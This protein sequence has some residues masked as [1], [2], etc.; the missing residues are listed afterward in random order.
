MS[1]KD[2]LTRE[3][4]AARASL[5]SDLQYDV[6]F[7]QTL[8]AE[9]YGCEVTIRFACN[10]PGGSTFVDFVGEGIETAELNGR[11]VA[12]D[13][14]DG[15]RLRLEGLEARNELHVVATGTYERSGVGL[16]RFEDPVDGRVYTHSDFEPF[17]AHRA[18]PCFDQPDLKGAFRFSVRTPSD[19]LAVSNGRQAGEPAPDGDGFVRWTFEETPPISPY[20]TAL[21]TGPFHVVREKG[22]LDLGLW[23]RQSLAEY[24]DRDAAELFEITRQGFAFFQ[25]RFDYPYPFGVKYDQVFVPDFIP[26][27]MENPGCITYNELYLFRS[28]VTDASRERRAE[29][30][31]HEMAHMWFGDLVT[32]RW[33]DDVWLNESFATYVSV[34]A[35]VEGTR[36]ADAWVTFADGEKTWAYQQ[37]QLPT[38]HAITTDV[39]DTQSI[40]LNFDGITYAKGASV[41]KQLVAWVGQDE[42]FQGLRAYFRRHEWSNTTLSDFLSALEETSGRD[43]QAWSKEWLETP[44]LNTLRADFEV[45]GGNGN[46]DG[47]TFSSFRISQSTPAEWP[48]LRSHRLAVGLYEL[49]DG[50]LKRRDRVELDVNGTA[51]VPALVGT[52]VP[53]LTLVNDDDL[54]YSKIRLDPRSR[55]TLGEHLA[56]IEDPL[57]RALCWSAT[58]DMVRDAELPVREYVR[59][60]VRHAPAETDIGTLQRLLAQAR[61]GTDAFGAPENRE[62]SFADLAES[63][64]TELQGAEAGSERQLAWARAWIGS[65]GHDGLDTM[66]GLLAGSTAVDGLQIDTDLRWAL[67]TRI[68]TLDAG[69]EDLI[70]AEQER[71]ATSLGRDHAQAARAARPSAEAKTRAW[72]AALEVPPPPA[73]TLGEIIAGFQRYGQE[74]LLTPYR[75]RFFEDLPTFWED[76]D[77]QTALTFT[78]AAYPFVIIEQATL[79]ATDEYLAA[80]G[81]PG[82]A[83]RLLIEGRDGVRR[84]LAA[85][86]ADVA[87]STASVG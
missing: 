61:A 25:D 33:W 83:Q 44:G 30:I 50:N 60:V 39:P 56:D 65:S 74:E 26:G 4:A 79:D 35:L 51:D 36:F 73:A 71:D 64:W 48:V 86:A 76:R 19:W 22:D 87:A 43:L 82:P 57:A 66:R 85:R 5:L 38:T 17:D 27:A 3:E 6:F 11:P 24:L 2:N 55:G 15:E 14:Y 9:T 58:W 34:L 69:A 42:F 31:L 84:A 81:L 28:R 62:R 53:A 59:L 75:A 80:R 13:A 54:T 70:A 52:G 78:R 40:R 10:E 7:D 23:C 63:A 20:V 16:H 21:V 49:A 32:M 68:A 46:G 29:T 45:A 77:M 72:A 18:Y 41:L 47:G 37:D 67:V 1:I 8:G 12:G